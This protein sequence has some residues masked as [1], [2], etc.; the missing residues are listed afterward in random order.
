MIWNK[1]YRY[2]TGRF[3]TREDAYSSRLELIRK[4]YPEE[5]FIKKVF[6]IMRTAFRKTVILSLL[7]FYFLPP[8]FAST[9]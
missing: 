4:G 3:S 8:L 9:L 6:K 2:T 5:I 1:F 7:L